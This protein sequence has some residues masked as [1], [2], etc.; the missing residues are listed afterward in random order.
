MTG[1]QSIRD[2]ECNAKLS[3][4][5][6]ALSCCRDLLLV[7]EMRTLRHVEVRTHVE[8]AAIFSS[9]RGMVVSIHVDV[10]V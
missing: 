7:Y 1:I 5:S 9:S 8:H 3:F 2:L 10:N 6:V 4:L